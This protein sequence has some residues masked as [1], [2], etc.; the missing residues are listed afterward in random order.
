MEVYTS[1]ANLNKWK[2]KCK[3]SHRH[4]S[5]SRMDERF[6]KVLVNIHMLLNETSAE[7]GAKKTTQCT[8]CYNWTNLNLFKDM[9]SDEVACCGDFHT[10]TDIKIDDSYTG[11]L[12]LLQAVLSFLYYTFI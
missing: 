5:C 3:K 4:P 6:K 9:T 2:S 7:S 12:C 1:D 8:S 11:F 10:A